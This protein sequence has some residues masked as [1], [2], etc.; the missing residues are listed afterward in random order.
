MNLSC[1]FKAGGVLLSNGFAGIDP[2]HAGGGRYMTPK[3]KLIE[4]II[5]LLN[6]ADERRLQA[7]YQFVLNIIK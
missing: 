7:I 5:R 1:Y 6:Q 2:R 3:E 4:S